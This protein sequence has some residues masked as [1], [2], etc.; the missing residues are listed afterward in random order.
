MEHTLS[1][2]RWHKVADRLSRILAEETNKVKSTFN[3]TKVTAYLGDKQTE[4]LHA[5]VGN[6][7][8]KVTLVFEL[9]EAVSAIRSALG[10]ANAKH[11]ISA[12][13]ADLE[14]LNRKITL[15]SELVDRQE[16]S[17]VGIDELKHVPASRFGENSYGRQNQIEVRMLA[18]DQVQ[19]LQTQREALRAQSFNLA[20]KIADLNRATITLALTEEISKLGGLK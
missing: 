20:D 5:A 18:A 4:Q 7:L 17:W 15:L 12:Q 16:S 2:A 6:G 11:G 1:L 19:A 9:M 14:C 8:N 10:D 3:G 13:L